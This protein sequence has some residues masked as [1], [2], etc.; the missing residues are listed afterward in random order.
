MNN[1]KRNTILIFLSCIL[2]VSVF[3]GI[4]VA[5]NANITVNGDIKTSY[6]R[7]DKLIVPTAKLS[8]GQEEYDMKS[9]LTFPDGRVSAEE[10]VTLD[11]SGSY[12]LSY[13]VDVE[14]T[15]YTKDYYFQ[16]EDKFQSLFTYG[17]NI[18]CEGEMEI[19]SYITRENYI[20]RTEG[21]KYTFTESGATMRYNGIVDLREIGFLS[22]H[23]TG[24]LHTEKPNEFIEFLVTPDDNTTKEINS[25]EIKIIDVYD[26]SNYIRIDMTAGDKK[27]IYPDTAYT[28]VSY[29]D[30]YDSM[31]YDN[32]KLSMTGANVGTSFYGQVGQKN[33]S[34]VRFY[35]ALDTLSY[36]VFPH[37]PEYRF[38]D[39]L[40]DKL[41]DTNTVGLGNEWFGFTTGEVYIEFIAK[42]LAQKE[43]SVMMLSVAGHD[44]DSFSGGDTVISVTTGDLDGDGDTLDVD[45]LP[46]AIA[47]ANNYYPVF[48]A[49][50]YNPVGGILSGVSTNVYYGV[51][52]DRENV[53]IADG[54]FKTEKAGDYYIEYVLDGSAYGSCK[55][56]IKVEAKSAYDSADIPDYVLSDKL[57]TTAGIG[58]KVFF[59]LG[60]TVGGSGIW[61][62]NVKVETRNQYNQEWTEIDT[63]GEE[64]DQYIVI[65]EPGE[66]K[67]TFTGTDMVGTAISKTHTFTVNYDVTPRLFD[68][69]MQKSAL[70]GYS[71]VFPKADAK[72]IGEAGESEVK[73]EVFV[74]GEDYTNRPYIVQDDFTVIYKATLLADE[75]KTTQKAY[76]VKAVDITDLPDM[77]DEALFTQ[78]LSSYFTPSEKV[79]GTPDIVTSIVNGKNILFTTS[80]DGAKVKLNGSV[81]FENFDIT[82]SPADVTNHS[83]VDIILTDYSDIAE[84]IRISV[85]K[86]ASGKLK[87]ALNGVDVP[88]TVKKGEN[89]E[90]VEPD[91]A[92][93]KFYVERYI[94][95]VKLSETEKRYDEKFR[96]ILVTGAYE[97][98][99]ELSTFENGNPFNGFSSKRVY[100]TLQAKGVTSQTS[101]KV[102]KICNTQYKPENFVSNAFLNKFIEISDSNADS[103]ADFETLTTSSNMIFST[104]VDGASFNFLRKIPVDIFSIVF[105]ASP[106]KFD[107]A[108]KQINVYLTDSEKLDEQVKLSVLKVEKNGIIY[109]Q[110]ALNDKPIKAISGSLNGASSTPFEFTYR[111]NE[112]A[113]YDGLGIK[114]GVI[115]AFMNGTEFNGF[116]SGYVYISMELEGVTG[117]T[118]VRLKKIANQPFN[119]N[120][121]EDSTDAV[122]LYSKDVSR[123]IYLNQGSSHT[124][125]SATAYDVLSEVDSL[126]VT[127]ENPSRS[128]IYNGA[129]NEDKSFV[130][131]SLGQY[132][133]TYTAEDSVGNRLKSIFYVYVQEDVAPTV[134][135]SGEPKSV[136]TVG[137]KIKIGKVTVTDNSDN[138]CVT[139]IYIH[140]PTLRLELVKA[141]SEFTFTEAGH[142]TL[143]YYA[144][145]K[146]YNRTIVTYEIL[147]VEKTEG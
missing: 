50:A 24:H 105:E 37:T 20:G 39:K 46:Y 8:L 47:G 1:K 122:I 7:G 26:E 40:F 54:K 84:T 2:L 138:E 6:A 109:T 102:E 125:Y 119:A 16:T 13:S 44:L 133:I 60:Q 121:V 57:A 4:A 41:T 18:Y 15:P 92:K 67:V 38:T 140:T 86:T 112:K 17:D 78:I 29:G 118:S 139:T 74:G 107:N 3:L 98:K 45:N 137:D 12:K 90:T 59:P 43:A 42:E 52:E 126:T 104:D 58:D 94:E 88:L 49:I 79:E 93:V 114:L 69:P 23:R 27:F 141:D 117:D 129:I 25:I 132:R 130:F 73:V 63:L 116:S 77:D 5:Q 101:V 9:A 97:F 89:T 134:T 103:K 68:V 147:V 142:Y 99:T 21:V 128:K 32:I 34:S 87:L 136:Y 144:R 127:V 95:E 62:H 65:A 106:N 28:G 64:E 131:D 66:Y 115:D 135:V 19:P 10:K 36:Y 113:V 123:N 35:Y 53:V 124:I 81:L 33:A 110:F 108:F 100:L 56:V 14:G 82:L 111:K 70:K 85:I 55:K 61:S 22:S 31:G 51:G 11:V 75:S 143:N 30:K 76:N 48:D 146:Y 120:I 145:D 83:Q 71:L 91:F 80:V 72:Y 96:L